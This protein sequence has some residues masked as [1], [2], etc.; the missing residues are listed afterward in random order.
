MTKLLSWLA[1][2]LL[3]SLH[4][5][6]QDTTQHR[7]EGR[8]NAPDQLSK[9]YVILI[10]ADGFR[11]DFADKYDAEF[12]KSKRSLGVF[13]PSMIPS[14]PTLTFPNHYTLVTGLYPAH[15]GLVNNRYYDPTS[16]QEYSMGNK[17]MVSEGKWYG[18]TPL[19]VLAEKQGMLAASNFWVASE[20]DIQGVRP[21]YYYVY[22]EVTPIEQRIQSV[23]DW[24]S[25]PETKRP[26][27]ITFYLPEVDHDAH[28][29]G[30]EDP[31]VKKS[32]QFVDQA[33]RDLQAALDPLKLPINYVFVSDH[34]MLTVDNKNT[35]GLPAEIDTAAFRVPSGDAL[36][37]V[38]AK[39]PSRITSTYEALKK[40]QNF[41][42][43]LMSE[44]PEH[45][46]F[47]PT[48]DR[49][50][51]LGAILLVPKL[52][53]VFNLSRYPTNQGK[54][55]FDTRLPEMQ[56]SFQAWGPA[57]KIGKRIPPFENVD[58]Y[59]LVAQMLGLV[60]DPSSI[61]GRLDTWKK[62]LNLTFA[63]PPRFGKG[64]GEK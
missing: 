58:I 26:H 1:S 16:R 64:R 23:K 15:H 17:K 44:T 62:V 5:F 41:D 46:H 32:V 14:Y 11:S 8:V 45:W 2:F 63:N 13:A 18:G 53:R 47:R 19:W 49:Y 7:V 56:A 25:L 30:P 57:L 21:S 59:P 6:A 42:T 24:L 40:N 60:Y 43:Y 48:D 39:D 12:L 36:L 52:P 54:H 37:Q 28:A 50:N 20:A 33:I 35:M 9:P 29:F 4:T 3:L 27:F 51:R 22:N 10:S 38:H 55:G 61:D 34:G 31:R